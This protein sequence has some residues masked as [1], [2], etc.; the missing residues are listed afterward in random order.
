MKR[1]HR[2]SVYGFRL[3]ISPNNWRPTDIFFTYEGSRFSML[4][5]EIF[6][7]DH[8][9]LGT[10]ALQNIALDTKRAIREYALKHKNDWAKVHPSYII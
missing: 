5:V 7:N 10:V 4:Q 1:L 3:L 9:F 6:D 8:R 2:Y